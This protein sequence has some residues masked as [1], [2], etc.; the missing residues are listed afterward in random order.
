VWPVTLT[1]QSSRPG[2]TAPSARLIRLLDQPAAG[3]TSPALARSP[4]TNSWRGWTSRTSVDQSDGLDCYK[5]VR[6]DLQ[7]PLLIHDATD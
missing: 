5:I 6:A 4:G 7:G 2:Q 3:R 1:E